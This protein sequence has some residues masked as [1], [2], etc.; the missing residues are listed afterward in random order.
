MV[1]GADRIWAPGSWAGGG[2]GPPAP[3]RGFAGRAQRGGPGQASIE[4]FQID[5]DDRLAERQRAWQAGR[6]SCRPPN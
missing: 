6:G 2:A 3:G 1:A 4:T 5:G